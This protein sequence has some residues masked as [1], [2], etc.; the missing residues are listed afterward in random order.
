MN[1]AEVFALNHRIEQTKKLIIEA[2]AF[3]PNDLKH[4][5]GLLTE[6]WNTLRQQPAHTTPLEHELRELLRQLVAFDEPFPKDWE[7][8]SDRAIAEA[9]GLIDPG[10]AITWQYRCQTSDGLWTPWL[11]DPR[12]GSYDKPPGTVLTQHRIAPLEWSSAMTDE[13]GP[14]LVE[15]RAIVANDP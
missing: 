3:G 6:I 8:R 2:A 10:G 11:P 7:D 4:E 14:L 15:H 5:T 9:D 12:T 13:G 1:A